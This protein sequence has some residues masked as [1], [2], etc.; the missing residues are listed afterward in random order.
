MKAKDED[1]KHFYSAALTELQV[2][3]VKPKPSKVKDLIRLVKHWCKEYVVENKKPA[4]G[5]FPNSYLLEMVTIHAWEEA[6][7][8]NQFEMA[9]GFRAVMEKLRCHRKLD[10]VWYDNYDRKQVVFKR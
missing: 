3:F 5:F 10:I 8:P 6:G 1:T 7:S 4:D 2:E 9:V